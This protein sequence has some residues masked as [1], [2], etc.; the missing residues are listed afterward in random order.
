M[1]TGDLRD[2]PYKLL[3]EDPEINLSILPGLEVECQ[4]TLFFEDSYYLT[5]KKSKGYYV[6]HQ[7]LCMSV[8]LF[9]SSHSAQIITCCALTVLVSSSSCT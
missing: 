6:V 2:F 5:I 7:F 4:G 3:S 8:V 9:L 1:Y